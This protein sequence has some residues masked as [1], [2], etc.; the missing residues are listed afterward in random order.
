MGVRYLVADAFGSVPDVVSSGGSVNSSTESDAWG[1]PET[2]GKMMSYT[3]F[4][5]AGG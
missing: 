3:P 1:N 4:G 2:T 5:F